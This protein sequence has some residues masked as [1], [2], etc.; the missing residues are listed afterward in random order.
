VKHGEFV[1]RVG[2]VGQSVV[3]Q[4]FF[5]RLSSGELGLFGLEATSL[6]RRAGGQLVVSLLVSSPVGLVGL[7]DIS[8][9][10]VLKV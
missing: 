1:F 5:L 6:R 7:Q 4:D 2:G 9:R 8:Q 10:V 3:I